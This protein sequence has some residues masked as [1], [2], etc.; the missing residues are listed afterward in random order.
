L[1]QSAHTARLS[2][3]DGL[4]TCKQASSQR[5]KSKEG[6]AF[7][8]STSLSSSFIFAIILETRSRACWSTTQAEF[9]RSSSPRTAIWWR[10]TLYPLHSPTT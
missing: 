6:A 5:I 10:Q 9:P 8:Y 3:H 7:P 2:V 1:S 4:T